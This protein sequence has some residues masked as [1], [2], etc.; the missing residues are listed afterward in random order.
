MIGVL[1]L[2]RR[3]LEAPSVRVEFQDSVA[4]MI[5]LAIAAGVSAVVGA[6]RKVVAPFMR[7]R[8]AHKAEE[9]AKDAKEKTKEFTDNAKESAKEF[10]NDAKQTAKEFS[11][12]AKEAFGGASGDNK[13]LLA[14]ILGIIFGGLGFTVWLDMLQVTKEKKVIRT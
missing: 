6:E 2:Q 7:D 13:K 3:E 8:P 4:E 10:S 12:G 11:D 14:G 5:W 1:C 9:F